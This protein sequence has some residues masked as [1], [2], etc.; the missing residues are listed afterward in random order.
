LL[1]D[2]VIP[3]QLAQA[4][5]IVV[6][7]MLILLGIDVLWRAW[8]NR[9]HYH[10][11]RHNNQNPHF[12]AHSHAGE[13]EHNESRHQHDHDNEFPLRALLVG[14]IRGMAGSAALILLTLDA[15]PAIGLGLGYIALLGIGSISGMGF[16]AMIISIPVRAA[17]NKLTWLH[18]GLQ[19]AIGICTVES[20]T[21]IILR[22]VY[23]AEDFLRNMS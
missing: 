1:M 15:A 17:S 4:L 6:G 14:L 16:L 7:V 21:S 8:K 13:D 22:V 10:L 23:F 3:E 11:H 5:E 2:Q 20:G 12:H 19:F 18:N 9:I